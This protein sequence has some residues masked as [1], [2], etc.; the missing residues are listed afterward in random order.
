M[1]SIYLV[2]ALYNKPSASVAPIMQG[3]A[4]VKQEVIPYDDQSAAAVEEPTTTIA[5]TDSAAAVATD[6]GGRAIEASQVEVKLEQ[7][8]QQKGAGDAMHP[9]RQLMVEFLGPLDEEPEPVPYRVTGANMAPLGQTPHPGPK[10][11]GRG[12][13]NKQKLIVPEPRTSRVQAAQERSFKAVAPSTTAA[14]RLGQQIRTINGNQINADRDPRRRAQVGEGYEAPGSPTPA[15]VTLH[16][17]APVKQEETAQEA[18]VQARLNPFALGATTVSSSPQEARSMPYH[19]MVGRDQLHRLVSTMSILPDTFAVRPKQLDSETRIR[20]LEDE[21]LGLR[22]AGF[23]KDREIRKLKSELLVLGIRRSAVH[24]AAF[25]P[26]IKR[27]EAGI[28]RL[29]CD[30]DVGGPVMEL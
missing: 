5:T 16:S 19:P 1:A 29:R 3:M 18:S 30:E 25:E 2:N 15:S 27:A 23:C 11:R 7:H 26:S 13:M 17:H 22:Q 24:D 9:A 4:E 8:E 6:T 10:K 12:A 20:E 28:K 14:V 21:N